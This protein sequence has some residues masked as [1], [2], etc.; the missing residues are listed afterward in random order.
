MNEDKFQ[1]VPPII[2]DWVENMK[3][4]KQS[5]VSMNY[6]SML[7]NVADFINQELKKFDNT[8]IKNVV[9]FKKGKK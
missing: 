7:K 9:N 5:H 1:N 8:Q 2:K 4:A 3:T 6:Y